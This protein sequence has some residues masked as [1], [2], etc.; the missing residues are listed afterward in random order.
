MHKKLRIPFLISTMAFTSMNAMWSEDPKD[1]YETYFEFYKPGKQI[2]TERIQRLQQLV[3]QN[4]NTG[5]TTRHAFE[6]FKTRLRQILVARDNNLK[7]DIEMPIITIRRPFGTERDCPDGHLRQGSF[8]E[9]LQS[10][11]RD[12]ELNEAQLAHAAH[13]GA[14][15]VNYGDMV[16][17]LKEIQGVLDTP[18][19][20]TQHA[21]SAI[22]PMTKSWSQLGCI[23]ALVIC[24]FHYFKGSPKNLSNSGP[25][26]STPNLT[27]KA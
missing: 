22:N 17:R 27:T 20:I 21:L 23:L 1:L 16:L 9:W 5:K 13:V 24:Y 2:T 7:N 8:K 15:V 6:R 25:Q 26:K 10:K 14:T 3:E 19:G 12:Y 11:V 4:I 18:V